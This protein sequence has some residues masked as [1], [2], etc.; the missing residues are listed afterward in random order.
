MVR[1]HFVPLNEGVLD[2]LPL[3][4]ERLLDTVG[5][6]LRASYELLVPRNSF[7]VLSVPCG[8]SVLRGVVRAESWLAPTLPCSF[9]IYYLVW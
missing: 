8:P 1:F 6:G 7:R 4:I 5:L 2:L 3:I 9:P